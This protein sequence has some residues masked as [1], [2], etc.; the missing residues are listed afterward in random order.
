M[1]NRS[2]SPYE[3]VPAMYDCNTIEYFVR[4]GLTGYILIEG[5]RT[6]AEAEREIAAEDAFAAKA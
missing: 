4:N 6:M 2:D 5:C 1:P 3:I